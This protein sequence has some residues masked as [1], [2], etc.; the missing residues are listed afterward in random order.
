MN[1]ISILDCTL[2][3]GGYVNDFDFSKSA[4]Q[5]II[6]KL[7]KAHMDIIECGFLKETE[8]DEDKSLYC[9]VHQ[10]TPLITPKKEGTM[11]VAMI[12]TGTISA[13]KIAPRTKETIDGIRITFH[14]KEMD[15]AFV[16]GY[17][18][19][20]KGYEIFMQPVGTTTYTDLMLLDLV[21]RINEMKPF[22]FYLVDTLGKLYAKQLM[23]L[24]YLVDDNLDEE[25]RIGYHSHNNLQLSFSNAQMLIQNSGKRS[26]IIDGSV[27]GMGRGAGNLCSEIMTQYINETME[28]RY[29]T[30]QLIELVDEYISP[31]SFVH[32]WGYNA[33][34][35]LAATNN[36]HPNYVTF[37]MNKQT[38]NV[39]RIHQILKRIPEDER[40]LYNEKTI[41]S[42][43]FKFQENII[44]D[45]STKKDLKK[46]IGSRP[47]AVMAPGRS[48]IDESETIRA[49]LKDSHY[50][51]ISVNY[52]PEDQCQ[53]LLFISNQKRFYNLSR[54]YDLESDQM[55]VLLTSNIK[56]QKEITMHANYSDLIV[57]DPMISDNACLML[58][59]LLADMGIT[60]VHVIGF[61]GYHTNV[62]KNY[63]SARYINSSGR[64][65]LIQINQR[66]IRQI[67]KI[68]KSLKLQYVTSSQ[69]D[70]ARR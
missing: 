35:F 55:H 45:S 23:K 19:M 50:F 10:I 3:D 12:V 64:E 28:Y 34:Y 51:V 33:A 38:L 69:Y 18:L 40:A 41:N 31:I 56:T 54:D 11:Y 8:Y 46:M 62:E 39:K 9:D 70:T 42:L 26:L 48:L 14:R 15:E 25:I 47:V 4:I 60:E 29:R 24:F 13:D 44:D 1:K 37:L 49:F 36:C 20:E 68:E 58:F 59:H 32:P 63:Y 53:D 67:K 66:M 30:D 65:K 21:G 16:L 6:T 17:A 57:D 22:A 7:G 43:Y 61:D 27:L 5:T 52:V 2:R